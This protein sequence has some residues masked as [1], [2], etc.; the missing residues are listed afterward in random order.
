MVPSSRVSA[1]I[2][3][4]CT[5]TVV[6]DDDLSSELSTLLATAAADEQVAP[7]AVAAAGAVTTSASSAQSAAS[8][9]EGSIVSAVPASFGQ[10]SVSYPVM[11]SAPHFPHV[12]GA[13]DP[14]STTGVVGTSASFADASRRDRSWEELVLLSCGERGS[15]VKALSDY[16]R[17]AQPSLERV[18]AAWFSVQLLQ[19]ESV[20]VCETLAVLLRDGWTGLLGDLLACA[21][22]LSSADA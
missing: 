18:E 4:L 13:L 7:E 2:P 14:A 10:S 22:S 21:R 15:A 17:Q 6:G 20:A 5:V 19:G 9:G 3:W 16:L 1:R 8:P 11:P 12:V